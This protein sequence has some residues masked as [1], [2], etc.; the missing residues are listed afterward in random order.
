MSERKL[1]GWI[2]ILSNQPKK[3]IW[4]KRRENETENEF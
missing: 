1:V 3:D 2:E 4:I